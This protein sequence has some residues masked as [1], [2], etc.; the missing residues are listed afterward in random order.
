MPIGL[1]APA[2]QI[3][4]AL[5]AAK[6]SRPFGRRITLITVSPLIYLQ[7]ACVLANKKDQ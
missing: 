7:L 5:C 6:D 4:L 2:S 1:R 3:S